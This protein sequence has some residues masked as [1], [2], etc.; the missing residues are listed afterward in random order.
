MDDILDLLNVHVVPG[1]FVAG[2]L[3]VVVIVG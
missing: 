2:L 1:L 3:D